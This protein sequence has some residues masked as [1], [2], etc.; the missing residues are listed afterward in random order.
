ME[1][2][3]RR[4]IRE[5]KTSLAPLDRSVRKSLG[6]RLASPGKK[7]FTLVPGRVSVKGTPTLSPK[8]HSPPESTGRTG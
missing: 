3:A 2:R 6:K 5:L 4:K 1:P 8:V 7:M